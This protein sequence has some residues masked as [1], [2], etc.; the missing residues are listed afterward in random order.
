M[1]LARG[2]IR[3]REWGPTVDALGAAIK[4]A[5]HD[6]IDAAMGSTPDERRWES[7]L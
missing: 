3:W 2:L 6:P 5:D 4:E 7:A 1:D